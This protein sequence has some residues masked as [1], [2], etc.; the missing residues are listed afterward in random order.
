MEFAIFIFLGAIM[1]ILSIGVGVCRMF[2]VPFISGHCR[3]ADMTKSDKKRFSSGVLLVFAGMAPSLLLLFYLN[4][5][6][7]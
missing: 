7:F 5:L 4:L 1:S 3:Y 2:S 6:F